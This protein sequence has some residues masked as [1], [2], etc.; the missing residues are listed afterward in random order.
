[1]LILTGTVG[2][3]GA[4]WKCLHRIKWRNYFASYEAAEV[5]R[6][7]KRRRSWVRA[8][9]YMS[10]T[11]LS[12]R[13]YLRSNCFRKIQCVRL[14]HLCCHYMQEEYKE[15]ADM[16]TLDCGHNFHRECVKKWLMQKNICPICKTTGLSTWDVARNSG[17]TF[18]EDV[19]IL[20]NLFRHPCEVQTDSERES[21][22][23]FDFKFS[24]ELY[25]LIEIQIIFYLMIIIE[26]SCIIFECMLYKFCYDFLIVLN[27]EMARCASINGTRNVGICTKYKFG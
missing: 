26:S 15:E 14:V 11:F 7:S 9:L 10:G 17:L 27:D 16:G 13:I 23:P 19:F 2:A 24:W 12:S 22:T 5:R 20:L 18:G 25:W 1:M 4:H 3:G 6:R 8:V 21:G